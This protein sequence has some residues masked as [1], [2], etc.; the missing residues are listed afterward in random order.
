MAARRYF[1]NRIDTYP[2]EKTEKEK[3]IR[4]VKNLLHNN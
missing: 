1:S 3:E 2:L 4:I